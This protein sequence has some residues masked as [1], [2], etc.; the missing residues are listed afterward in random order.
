MAAHGGERKVGVVTG[1]STGLGRATAE[2]LLRRGWRVIAVSRDPDRASLAAR[3]FEEIARASGGEVESRRC[4]LSRQVEVRRL[5][6]SLGS[7]ARIDALIHGA[8]ALYGS[9]RETDEGH[10]MTFALGHLAPFLLTRLLHDKLFTGAPARII[11]ISSIFH[12]Q[13]TIDF[14]DIDARRRY[15]GLR[16]YG[17]A[18]LANLLFT[19]ELARRHAGEGVSINA[20]HPGNVYTNAARNSGYAMRLMYQIIAPIFFLSAEEGADTIVWA[21][22]AEE[23]GRHSG[24]LLCKRAPLESSAMSRDVALGKRLWKL[25]EELTG[26]AWPERG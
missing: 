14:D 22:T 24:E 3:R 2:A 23:A 10:E 13:G 26:E 25:T 4:D 6:A 21:A 19:Y 12:H 16:A 17:Q 1:A 18:K 15:S 5:A 11:S 8:G 9:R 7:I 20:V